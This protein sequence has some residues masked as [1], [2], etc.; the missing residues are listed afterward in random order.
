M[1][2][3]KADGQ[4]LLLDLGGVVLGINFRRVF[5]FWAQAAG[6]DE[7]VFY[8]HWRLD[9]AY[10]AQETGDLDFVDY[11]AHLS[12]T[13]SVSM[14]DTQWRDGWNALWT[15]PYEEVAAL[16]PELKQRFRLF[17]YSNTNAVHAESFLQRYPHIFQH[18]EKLFL[19]HE[20]GCCK[21]APESFLTVCKLMQCQPSEVIFLDDSKENIAGA[22]AAGLTAYLT[23]SESEVVEALRSL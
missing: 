11:T 18:F 14:S 1:R 13:L 6:V 12:K 9:D 4:V 10:K 15:A 7:A 20:V 3:S 19:S 21:P 2:A 16:F 5:T 8:D 23:R 22:E 17:A